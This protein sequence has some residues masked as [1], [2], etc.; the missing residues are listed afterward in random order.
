MCYIKCSQTLYNLGILY[1][2]I[3]EYEDNLKHYSECLNMCKHISKTNQESKS[4]IDKEEVGHMYWC[5]AQTYWSV[6]NLSLAKQY[7]WIALKIFAQVRR[8]D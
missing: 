3:K 2:F 1:V 6:G 4:L 7:N 5:M 8:K